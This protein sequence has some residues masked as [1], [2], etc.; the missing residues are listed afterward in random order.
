MQKETPGS[1][2]HPLFHINTAIS[3]SRSLSWRL[4]VRPELWTKVN[5]DRLAVRSGDPDTLNHHHQIVN[6]VHKSIT[7]GG[8]LMAPRDPRVPLIQATNL[9]DIQII[10][11]LLEKQIFTL[12]IHSGSTLHLISLS[13]RVGPHR[14][15]QQARKCKVRMETNLSC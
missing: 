15:T 3:T 14:C 2:Q 8:E 12:I 9:P 13:A 4:T 11:N 5:Q 6:T 10:S 1:P 7:R